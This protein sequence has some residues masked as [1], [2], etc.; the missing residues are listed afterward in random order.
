M[1]LEPLVVEPIVLAQVRDLLAGPLGHLEF[2]GI[3][4]V[5]VLWRHCFL[6]RP[7]GACVFKVHFLLESLGRLQREAALSVT[8][9]LSSRLESRASRHTPCLGGKAATANIAEGCG[10]R[11]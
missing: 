6:D 2:V 9:S 8:V 4:D 1:V 7:L 11:E 5:E 10:S 3:L